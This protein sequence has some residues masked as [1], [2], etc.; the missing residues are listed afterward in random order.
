MARRPALLLDVMDTLVHDPFHR[1]IP[2]YFGL[3]FAEFFEQ[4]HPTAWVEFERGE[5][6]PEEYAANM[7]MDRRRV[8]WP[9]FE[10]HVK[11]AYEFIPGVV[12]LLTELRAA[13]VEMHA[14]SNYPVLYRV[15]DEAVGLSSFVTL[16]FVSCNTRRR[17]PEPDAYLEAAREIGRAPGECLFV[18]DR[19]GN[20]AAARAVGMPSI[21]FRDAPSLRSE[22]VTRGVL[23]P[24]P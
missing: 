24:V 16:S 20:C 13:E 4:K 19:E 14:L 7:F 5:L 8:H 23:Q 9:D 10:R 2:E 17:K 6:N 15:L 21:L 11:N 1:A 22:L 18:D 12:E 3:S